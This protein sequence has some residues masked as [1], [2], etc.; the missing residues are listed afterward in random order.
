MNKYKFNLIERQ[1]LY[2][3]YDKRCFYC[4]ELVY[5][6]ELQIDHVVPE[7]LIYNKKEYETFKKQSGLSDSFQINS[8][9]N[10]VPSHSRCNNRKSG[11]M[12]DQKT[13]LYYLELVKRKIDKILKIE[14]SI[15]SKLDSDILLTTITLA[16]SENKLDFSEIKSLVAQY[17]KTEKA[18]FR[19]F[20][21]LEF[22]DR[23][24]RNWISQN[25]FEELLELP[26]KTGSPDNEGVVLTDPNDS[27]L[28]VSVKNCQEY[29]YYTN[30]G[31]YA[32]TTYSM[33]MSAFFERT[34]GLIQA[35]KNATIPS[36][37][38]I[39]GS[40]ISIN[41]FELLPLTLFHSFTPETEDLIGSKTGLTFQDW[42]NDGSFKIIELLENG[43]HIVH[44]GEGFIM[45]ELL[46]ADLNDDNVEDI[47][48]FC[49]SY[50]TEGTLGFGYTNIIT[51]LSD[52][53]KF[54][55]IEKNKICT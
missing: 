34:C 7:N 37:N 25:D 39:S 18:K 36:F 26:V 17:D 16:L 22:V 43:F 44:S 1:S 54:T 14:S 46:R 12:F 50:A 33:K 19:L 38:F 6:R 41:N 53:S 40:N 32:Y 23:L 20:S 5:F 15:K 2:E 4:G 31:Y 9:Q 11:A 13:T 3:A 21:E 10:W 45:V 30:K 42:I 48:V 51:R 55:E 28:K 49:Y 52:E 29:F 35:L 27:S 8:Y 47:L 24:Y